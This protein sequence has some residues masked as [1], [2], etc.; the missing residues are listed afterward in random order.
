MHINTELTYIRWLTGTESQYGN[1]DSRRNGVILTVAY[2]RVGG[3]LEPPTNEQSLRAIIPNLM[4]G[5][6]CVH[7]VKSFD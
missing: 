1:V 3:V 6:N 7:T 5:C 4:N 2:G